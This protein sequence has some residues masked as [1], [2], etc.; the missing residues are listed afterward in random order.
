MANILNGKEVAKSI[1]EEVA[2]NVSKMEE[3]FKVRPKLVTIMVGEDPASKTYIKMKAKACARV[4]IENQIINLEENVSTEEVIDIIHY[5]NASEDVAGI[6]IQHP[7]PYS[8]DE[9]KCFD[10]IAIE[11]DIDGVNSRS[12]GAMAMK[13]PAFHSATP[14]AIMDILAYYNLDVSGKRAVVIGRSPILGKPVSMLLLN[15]DATVT[16]CHSKTK[17]IEAIIKEAD[18]VV[19]ALGKPE[20]VQADWVKDGA[21]LIDAGYNKGNIGDI[22]RK[23]YEKSS[24][25]TPV[26]GGVG[27]VTIAEVL[28]NTY[29]AKA[30][31]LGMLKEEKKKNPQK[32][33][34]FLD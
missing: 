32:T 17:N 19:A 4:N 12:F 24:F 26:P 8:V 23:A 2:F 11:K 22:D 18:I 29:L 16:T 6:L 31:S 9:Q 13:K 7:L 3:E 33:R 34:K 5:L 20:F 14:Q 27:P 15:A 25:Y 10:E 1:E 30:Y 21:I 28:K